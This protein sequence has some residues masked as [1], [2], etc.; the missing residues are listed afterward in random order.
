MTD[1]ICSFCRGVLV[2]P[3]FGRLPLPCRHDVHEVCAHESKL[4]GAAGACPT[5]GNE[6]EELMGADALCAK[7]VSQHQNKAFTEAARFAQAALDL[8]E[9]HAEAS[10]LLGQLL[11]QGQGMDQDIGKGVRLLEMAVNA[12][13]LS[14][15]CALGSLYADGS[16][17]R[18][19]V[20][21]AAKLLNHALRS[22]YTPAAVTL[23]GLHLAGEGVP[24]SLDL[25]IECFEMALAS[26]TDISP[27]AA[28]MMGLTLMKRAQNGQRR[29]T[30]HKV[31]LSLL[32]IGHEGDSAAASITLW[33]HYKMSDRAKA[34]KYVEAAHW[35]SYACGVP[36]HNATFTW[37]SQ[38]LGGH[39]GLPKDEAKGMHLFAL[40][41]DG[42]HPDAREFLPQLVV[43]STPD[44]LARMAE[45]A[46][47]LF[48]PRDA[49]NFSAKQLK[50]R[51]DELWP[52][53][54]AGTLQK[55][56]VLAGLNHL[57]TERNAEVSAGFSDDAVHVIQYSRHPN[58]LKTALLEG[59]ELRACRDALAAAGLSPEH[60]TGAK[61]FVKPEQYESVID[62]LE[63]SAEGWPLKPWHVVVSEEFE[64]AVDKAVKSLPSKAQV[65]EKQRSVVPS[66]PCAACGKTDPRFACQ[67]CH[68]A[69]YCS[70]A[71]QQQ[72]WREHKKLCM[73]AQE[74]VDDSGMPVVLKRTFLEVPL[75]TSL[76]SSPTTGDRTKSTTD[77]DPRK[78]RNPR[79]A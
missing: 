31:A 54:K 36:M 40:A 68:L 6:C 39:G 8:Q 47:V 11:V 73:P 37:G 17:V 51:A 66:G 34:C 46:K 76:R 27:L 2:T 74:D 32:E 42:G 45:S 49:R 64:G 33:E 35:A 77:A 29:L 9:D 48:G 38:C 20:K 24:K 57:V 4:K 79:K 26:K 16:K 75:K 25:A 3:G 56:E 7:A 58:S 71:C 67:R 13:D 62:A 5:C 44:Q 28:T 1:E 41:W 21:K 63:G 52:R 15:T 12:G 78:G 50:K 43:G 70:K 30:D 61:I 53:M 19:N 14:A 10:G 55:S 65:R 22:G 69:R 60:H 18:K 23:G 59:E 72:N